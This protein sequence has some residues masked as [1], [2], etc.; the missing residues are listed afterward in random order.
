MKTL[1]IIG[2]AES[3]SQRPCRISENSAI[4]SSERVWATLSAEKLGDFKKDFDIEFAGYKTSAGHYN[5]SPHVIIHSMLGNLWSDIYAGRNFTIELFDFDVRGQTTT[6][7]R[8]AT[9]TTPQE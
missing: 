4:K 6:I 9:P 5:R 8:R 1:Y 2:N 7:V 3:E